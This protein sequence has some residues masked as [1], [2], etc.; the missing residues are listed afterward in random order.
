M[1]VV[2]MNLG[3]LYESLYDALNQ[4]YMEL[5]NSKIKFSSYLD[6]FAFTSIHFLYRLPALCRFRPWN[7]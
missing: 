7:S 2:L 4:N 1:T 3:S 6:S 5:G